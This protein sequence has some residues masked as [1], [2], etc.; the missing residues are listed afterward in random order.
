[1][2]GKPIGYL[3]AETLHEGRKYKAVTA[4]NA[5]LQNM[6]QVSEEVHVV[7]THERKY[8]NCWE[9]LQSKQTHK[10][11]DSGT[12]RRSN[13]HT[14]TEQNHDLVCKQNECQQGMN[15]GKYKRSPQATH[16]LL[17]SGARRPRDTACD[18][19]MKPHMARPLNALE[20]LTCTA[21]THMRSGQRQ[22][23]TLLMYQGL[24]LLVCPPA[25]SYIGSI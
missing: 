24:Q 4:G 16:L 2:L 21:A 11:S 9:K 20:R 10:P 6:T 22:H 7:R 13:S 14:N 5:Q 8:S 18:V 15:P 19:T 25:N 3:T 23:S 12:R 1:M 17:T